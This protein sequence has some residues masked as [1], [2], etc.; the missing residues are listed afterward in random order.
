MGRSS[1]SGFTWL[2]VNRHEPTAVWGHHLYCDLPFAY[3]RGWR[4]TRDL[5]LWRVGSGRAIFIFEALFTRLRTHF[6]PGS[7]Q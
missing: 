6:P 7:H 5:P 2:A 1:F 4:G 3:S